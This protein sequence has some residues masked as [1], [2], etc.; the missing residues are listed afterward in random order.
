MAISEVTISNMALSRIGV[1]QR[2]AS[3]TELSAE[4]GACNLWYELCRDYV[5]ED[6]DWSFARKRVALTLL[7]PQDPPLPWGYEFSWPADCIAAREID[8]GVQIKRAVDRIPFEVVMRDA[9]SRKILTTIQ[10]PTLIYTARVTNPTMFSAVFAD[11]VSLRMAA[12][13]AMGIAKSPTMRDSLS[14]YYLLA[15]QT[16][17]ARDLNQGQGLPEPDSEFVTERQ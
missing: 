16:A 10:D 11:A 6:F 15:L 12:E 13:L 17:V 3:M 4:A 8:P 1:S 5:L 2:I 9:T 14:R 7:S